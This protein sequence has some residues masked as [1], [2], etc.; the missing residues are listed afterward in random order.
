MPRRRDQPDADSVPATLGEFAGSYWWAPWCETCRK[1]RKIVDFAP[2]IEAYGP[3][4]PMERFVAR[5]R[6]KACGARCPT[7]VKGPRKTTG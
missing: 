3:D 4:L 1:G 5:L 2:Y 7:G 6:C